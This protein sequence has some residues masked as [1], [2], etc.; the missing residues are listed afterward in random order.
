MNLIQSVST[1]LPAAIMGK[2]LMGKPTH[3]MIIGMVGA[4]VS[5]YIVGGMIEGVVND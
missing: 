1:A 5:G 4:G 3:L 2:V